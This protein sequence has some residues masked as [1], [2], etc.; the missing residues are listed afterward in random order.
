MY[1]ISADQMLNRLTITLSGKHTKSD[2]EKVKNEIIRAVDTL[3]PGFSVITN[4]SNF[5]SLDL[6]TQPLMT[7]I[8]NYLLA[9][10][11]RKIIRVVGASKEGLLTFAQSTRHLKGYNVLHVAT[12]DDALK[13]LKI[14]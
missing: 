3:N 4:I 11:C 8:A 13:E 10:K 14:I 12:M 2:T 7:E 6:I 9:R 5:Q 1:R